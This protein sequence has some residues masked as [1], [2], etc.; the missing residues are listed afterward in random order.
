MFFREVLGLNLAVFT[1][2]GLYIFFLII[3]YISTTFAVLT[4]AKSNL[5]VA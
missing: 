4:K 3:V 2:R 1:F 5:E